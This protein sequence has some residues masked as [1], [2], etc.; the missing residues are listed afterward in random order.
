MCVWVLGGGGGLVGPAVAQELGSVGLML[1][2]VTG[3]FEDIDVGAEGR[4]VFTELAD[5][6]DGFFLLL[7]D[8]LLAGQRVVLVDGLSEGG[9]GGGDVSN[10]GRRGR[11][12][13]GEVRE[14]GADGL[15]L[16][17]GR[18][19]GDVLTGE[20]ASLAFW[21]MGTKQAQG[22]D[23]GHCI[24]GNLSADELLTMVSRGW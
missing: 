7:G 6:L 1:G 8:N 4:E 24:G 11:L 15:A 13:G 23:A 9:K 21:Q 16:A 18:V 20:V 2:V 3:L 12:L 14:L 19:V 17:Q 10:F 22:S 5:A